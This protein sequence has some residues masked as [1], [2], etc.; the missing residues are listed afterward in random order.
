MLK[1]LVL[2]ASL[3]LGPAACS[4]VRYPEVVLP[5]GKP[6]ATRPVVAIIEPLAH[7]DSD[8][9]L[10]SYGELWTSQSEADLGASARLIQLL[11]GTDLFEEVDFLCQLSS[12]PNV[13]L[14]VVTQPWSRD[15]RDTSEVTFWYWM[16]TIGVVPWIET[17][18]YGVR[19]TVVERSTNEVVFE[20]EETSVVGW[21]ALF[22]NLSP[23]WHTERNPK[24]RSIAL[25]GLLQRLE[26]SIFDPKQ[27]LSPAEVGRLTTRCS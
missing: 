5:Q 7:L 19:F 25:A 6:P 24:A 14:S 27:W 9:L 12:Q 1:F 18:D 10:Q 17:L 22:I 4:T 8:Q 26:P 20:H 13:A 15:A 2:V 21:V 11:R 16:L 23:S 3:A